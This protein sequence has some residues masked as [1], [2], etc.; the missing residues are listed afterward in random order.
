[1]AERVTWPSTSPATFSVSMAM[2]GGGRTEVKGRS[3]LDPLDVQITISTRDAPIA[4]YQ[5]YFPFPA[6]FVGFFGGDS[7]S[8]IQR[9][10][11]GKLILAS[12]GQ[13][14]A[15]DFEVRP[16]DADTPVAR[17]ARLE[18][19]GL[20]FS[21]PNYALVNRVTLPQPPAQVER[22]SS[23][24]INLPRLFTAGEAKARPPPPGPG[25]SR[26]AQRADA[27]KSATPPPR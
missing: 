1:P 10:K 27:A 19:Q 24:A 2:P 23:G 13:A 6:R 5:A 25:A 12:R 20:D 26:A 4:P 9:A 21:W 15:R 7:L 11:D 22:D 17:L 14:S 18:I 3:K 16:P 8:E